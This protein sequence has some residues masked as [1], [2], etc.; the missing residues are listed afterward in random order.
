VSTRRQKPKRR[1]AAKRRAG[2]TLATV[3]PLHPVAVVA[4]Q[5]GR[6][7]A[8]SMPRCA[9]FGGAASDGTPCR[10]RVKDSRCPAH[11]T[12]A[13][14]TL[15]ANKRRA[16]ELLRAGHFLTEVA[17]SLEVDPAT[18]WRWRQA[19]PEFDDAVAA[20]ADANDAA[21]T[22]QVEET[23]FARIVAGTASAAETIFWL[24][25]RAPGRWKDK[26][27]AELL[28]ENGKPQ[29]LTLAAVQQVLVRVEEAR[30]AHGH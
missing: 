23:M 15:Q 18:L 16:V 12:A 3:T 22:Q 5:S 20:L 27:S 10:K 2:R 25:N 30:A 17:T 28:D 24:K 6:A 4:P 19:D 14:A 21:R 11:T 7:V 13:D 1:Q 29:R 26:I 8:R 9:D